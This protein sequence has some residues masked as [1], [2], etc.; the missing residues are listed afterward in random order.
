[1]ASQE[2]IKQ[3]LDTLFR[4]QMHERRERFVSSLQ[5]APV[6]AEKLLEYEVLT[7]REKI[8]IVSK[9]IRQHQKE[10][11]FYILA[12]KKFEEIDRIIAAMQAT[13]NE[14]LRATLLLLK[15][16]M[17]KMSP[18]DKN[19]L[20]KPKTDSAV[21]IDEQ[22]DDPSSD[23]PLPIF[24]MA[25]TTSPDSFPLIS[26]LKRDSQDDSQ[27]EGMQQLKSAISLHKAASDGHLEDLLDL[28]KSGRRPNEIE[29]NTGRTALHAAVCGNNS[30][31][32]MECVDNLVKFYEKNLAGEGGDASK[33]MSEFL[34]HQDNEKMTI[35]HLAAENES[36]EIVRQLYDKYH[37]DIFIE[38]K[39]GLTAL[40]IMYIKTPE[41]II[42]VLNGAI[43]TTNNHP[44]DG[45]FTLEIDFINVI[46][47]K[48]EEDISDNPNYAETDT[49]AK[50]VHQDKQASKVILPHVIVKTFLDLKWEKMKFWLYAS[51]WIQIFLHLWYTLFV[52]E[53]FLIVCPYSKSD[54]KSVPVILTSETTPAGTS[55]GDQ[56]E[57][58]TLLGYFI[59]PVEFIEQAFSITSTESKFLQDCTLSSSLN[60]Q[61]VM[62]LIIG[63]LFFLK[64][65]FELLL[66]NNIFSNGTKRSKDKWRNFLSG[67]GA[68]MKSVENI[69][70]LAYIVLMILVCT[71]AFRTNI[72]D[73]YY[74]S[75]ALSVVIAW[76]LILMQVG[77]IAGLG[78]YVQIL[79]KVI[80]SFATLMGT[81]LVLIIAFSIS[82]SIMF[83]EM[84]PFQT[85]PKSLSR[86][87]IMMTGEL[88]YDETFYDEEKDNGGPPIPLTGHIIYTS[89]TLLLTIVLINLLIGMVVSDVQGLRG[90]SE[91]ILR[92]IQVEQLYV[93]EKSLLRFRWILLP[94]KKI[95][96][97]LRNEKE[98]N[99]YLGIFVINPHTTSTGMV[100]KKSIKDIPMKLQKELRTLAGDKQEYMRE[101]S[102]KY[103]N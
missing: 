20:K 60:S 65:M 38:N 30:E 59:G 5:D 67:M 93:M 19:I 16:R 91:V 47:S 64:E 76:A 34:N 101:Y 85:L 92:S 6:V 11:L 35:M 23:R 13:G 74:S 28:L 9:P 83:P 66:V 98:K 54:R 36:V 3:K 99:P 62:L 33:K 42:H 12:Q 1:M 39:D 49:L 72:S 71:L 94:I 100:L 26:I 29:E 48:T 84:E 86:V 4:K 27:D 21:E 41:A 37:C 97:R 10:A 31:I 17:F 51:M 52:V 77:N 18:F 15:I 57:K 88:N 87:I 63:V 24:P 14:S 32:A 75:A 78:T 25:R 90:K 8:A 96:S 80:K 68:Y 53:V 70:Q 89:F 40:E 7:E 103:L 22:N 45:K 81:Y 95:L 44:S 56:P 46:G 43:P 2:E 79:G 73:F 50:L 102:R 69:F 61:A 55:S 82:F 58:R